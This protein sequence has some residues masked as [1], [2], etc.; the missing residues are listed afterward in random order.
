MNSKT[1]RVC[2]LAVCAIVLVAGLVFYAQKQMG[3]GGVDALNMYLSLGLF[4]VAFLFFE[5]VAAGS[6]FFAAIEPDEK[7][8][9][10]LAT[11][12]VVAVFC[13]GVSVTADA[14]SPQRFWE[15]WISPVVK[16]PIFLDIV[17]MS[18][19]LILGIALI[20]VSS[21]KPAPVWLRALLGVIAAV[22][23]IGTSLIFT[24]MSAALG[25]ESLLEI[26]YFLLHSALAGVLVELALQTALRKDGEDSSEASSVEFFR[27]AAVV[28]MAVYVLLSLA[29]VVLCFYRTDTTM[30]AAKGMI[31]GPYAPLFWTT[32]IGGFVLPIVLMAK[33]STP[34]LAI[35]LA[36]LGVFG[37]K[38]VYIFKGNMYPYVDFGTGI[39]MPML[40]QG[41]NGFQMTPM[42]LPTAQ[43]WVICL[44]FFA[45]FVAILMF[46]L[47]SVIERKED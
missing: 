12:G 34:K 10:P 46:A 19:V 17:T 32:L 31:T 9:R 41:M 8:R 28:L 33:N 25:F 43:E 21:K 45:V 24:G 6:F 26:A 42:Y 4:M 15:L 37:A 27:K 16:S 39:D 30:M 29:E 11:V 44:A 5:A 14:G 36:L 35:V 47:P 18:L 20:V 13:S 22:M 38:M 23:P 40:A 1:K 2:V 3:L 7:L